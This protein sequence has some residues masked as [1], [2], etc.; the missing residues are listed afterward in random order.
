[1]TRRK[2]STRSM[3]STRS[4]RSTQKRSKRS[5]RGGVRVKSKGPSFTQKYN[6]HRAQKLTTGVS[7]KPSSRR[8]R[9]PS[10]RAL[11]NFRKRR[12]LYPNAASAAAEMH[13]EKYANSV[14]SKTAP[15]DIPFEEQV[16]M[17]EQFQKEQNEQNLNS[18]TA[19][20]GRASISRP[21]RL[22]HLSSTYKKSK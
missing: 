6:T 17:V 4:K 2:R 13:A 14:S 16:S 15:N 19:A 1:M 18:M 3:C 22:H 8:V 11:R 12:Y 5:T 9:F 21:I 20:M 7:L 10:A